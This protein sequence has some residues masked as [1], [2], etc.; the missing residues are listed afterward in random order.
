MHYQLRLI[1]FSTPLVEGSE[2]SEKCN[3][4]QS[5]YYRSVEVILGIK[6]FTC[7]IDMWSMAAMT[8]ELLLGVPLFPGA[9]EYD[10]LTMF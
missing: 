4:L 8:A 7:A 1:D 5:R 10:M 6:P 9:S 3:R 2:D